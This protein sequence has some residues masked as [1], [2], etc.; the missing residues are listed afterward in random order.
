MTAPHG[1][2]N[3]AIVFFGV[4]EYTKSNRVARSSLNIGDQAE[5]R[6]QL[7]YY[8]GEFYGFEKTT[9]F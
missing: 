6:A 2:T 4:F 8:K 3:L 1:V 7:F 9:D 5:S